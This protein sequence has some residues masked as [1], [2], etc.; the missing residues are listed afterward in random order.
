MRSLVHRY[1]Y[2]A[3]L[4][5]LAVFMTTS[6]FMA[7]MMW[8]L[9]AANWVA[10]WNWKEKFGDFK[11][12][13]LLQA[14]AV[15]LA[16]H[17][18]WLVGTENMGYALFDL[19][20]KL[21]L[22]V[23]PLVVLT[24]APPSK[25]ELRAIGFCYITTILVVA[26][27]GVVRHLTIAD[28]PYRQIVPFISHIRFS[29]NI[30][31]AIVIL[32][33]TALKA[34]KGWI[35]AS[36]GLLVVGLVAFLLLIHSYTAFVILAVT[37]IVLTIAHRHQFPQK[38]GAMAAWA[39]IALI[40][41]GIGV[42]FYY[43][44][45]YYNLRPLSTQPLAETTA[46]GTPYTHLDDGLT[47]NGNLVNR[48]ICETEMRSEWA[49]LSHYPY[50]SVNADG[51]SIYPTL[52]RY[53]N[54]MG[55]TKDS[56]GMAQLTVQDIKA[57]ESGVANP[58]YLRQ[59]PRKMVYVMCFEYENYRHYHSVNNF[60]MLQRF[61]LW[62]NGWQIFK[63]HPLLGVGTGDV[64]DRC[65]KR[66]EET[67]SPLAGTG[68]HTHNQYL[69]FLLAFGLLGFLAIMVAF[70]RAIWLNHS[71]RSLLFTA[72]LCITLI[73]FITEDTLETLAGIL[74]VAL[75]FCLLDSRTTKYISK[76]QTSDN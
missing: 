50:D 69:N 15:L 26:V 16:V 40:L 28:L 47:E 10:E 20:K 75:G 13:H 49:K 27:I 29:L 59:G 21:P 48:Y 23:I 6:V 53:L 74:F 54:G 37:G 36:S 65:H 66:L 3:L 5:L 35:Y 46:N 4:C 19:Q 57:I 61:E 70:V 63:K 71:S 60:T 34:N 52:L 2:V 55:V 33:Y 32:A 62:N 67:H 45:D 9:L 25:K 64:V 51:Y 58:V 73:S 18:L 7:N 14:F 24:T 42:T 11:Q 17:L 12:N 31:L 76:K 22:F 44:H 41:C 38:A 8:V 56:A 68:L 39:I 30:C 43:C 72:F 1:I